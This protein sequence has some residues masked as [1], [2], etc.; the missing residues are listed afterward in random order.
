M[1]YRPIRPLLLVLSI[2]ASC[3]YH[4]SDG[5]PVHAAGDAGIATTAS[6]L[7]VCRTTCTTDTECR[8]FD[9]CLLSGATT[10]QGGSCGGNVN[11]HCVQTMDA[12]LA[13]PPPPVLTLDPVCGTVPGPSEQPTDLGICR[14]VLPT[15][16][17]DDDAFIGWLN[18]TAERPGSTVRILSYSVIGI[19]NAGGFHL[20]ANG[21]TWAGQW[22]RWFPT[23]AHTVV[24]IPADN[25]F[26]VPTSPYVL[27]MGG[28]GT[29]AGYREAYATVTF[30]T[31]GD[32]KA[33]LGGD[34]G[35]WTNS[36]VRHEAARTNWA[37]CTTGTITLTTPISTDPVCA[38]HTAAPTPPPPPPPPPPSDRLAHFTLTMPPHGTGGCSGTITAWAWDNHARRIDI[39]G[40]TSFTLD[41]TGQMWWNFLCDGSPWDSRYGWDGSTPRRLTD[42]GF[43]ADTVTVNGV[44]QTAHS[45]ICVNSNGHHMVVTAADPGLT[46][47]C[48]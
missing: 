11:I 42:A 25:V 43:P 19:D 14:L 30:Q 35:R 39:A 10:C 6:L 33:Q 3:Y 9:P 24:T 22:T 17:A 12:C 41:P 34:Y 44:D 20:I 7:T 23:D 47:R 1:R 40:T 21:I 15:V 36:G 27:H 32:V 48:P 37:S 4:V 5:D 29:L 8:V 2:T 18:I 31:T 38:P 26:T 28:G 45:R 46:D 16:P 13:A